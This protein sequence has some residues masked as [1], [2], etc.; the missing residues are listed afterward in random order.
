MASRQKHYLNTF[1]PKY[2]LHTNPFLSSIPLEECNQVMATYATF[3]ALGNS[4]LCRSIL[5][6][7]IDKYLTAIS[8]LFTQNGF[9]S[10]L[11]DPNKPN[12]R[13]PCI[14]YVVSEQRRW[15]KVPNRREPLTLDM[16][17]AIILHSKNSPSTSLNSALT[18]WFTLGVYMGPRLSEFAQHSASLCKTGVKRNKDD[19]PTAFILSDFEF[20]GQNNIRLPHTFESSHAASL[21]VTWRFQK[22]NR[23]GEVITYTRNH[24]NTALCPVLAALRI[25]QRAIQLGQLD[26]LPIAIYLNDKNTISYITDTHIESL[27]RNTAQS[28]YNITNPD[29]LKRFSAHSLRVGACVILHM[30]G[31]KSLT[32]KKRLRWVSDTFMTYLRDLPQLGDIHVSFINSAMGTYDSP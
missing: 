30:A 7:T 32:I 28:L 2:H 26:T 24:D 23:N 14:T 4:L 10:P 19:T 25:R 29:E 15:E 22:N 6:D 17:Q 3:L 11:T 5:A 12:K 16:L 20:R 13:A 18:D 9:P 27:L 1:C 21:R 8:D 31:S